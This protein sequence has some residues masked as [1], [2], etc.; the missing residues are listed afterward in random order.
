[1]LAAIGAAAID[2]LFAVIPAEYRRQSDLA[3][4]RAHAESEIIRYFQA[5]GEKNPPAMPAFWA[6]EPTGTTGR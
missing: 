6:R 5:A 4:P 3:V 1:M 2:E